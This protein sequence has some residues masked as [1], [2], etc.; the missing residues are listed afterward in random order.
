VGHD[1]AVVGDGPAGSAL[2]RALHVRGVDVILIGDDRPWTATYTTWVDDLD[3]VEWLDDRI[4]LH[5]FGS[6]AVRFERPVHLA[7]SYGVLDN[8]RLR[9]S[10][11]TDV[12]RRTARVTRPDE[13]EARLVIDATGWPPGL[14]TSAADAKDLDP[15]MTWQTAFGV[16]VAHAPDGPL[17]TPTMM[18]FSAP[19]IPGELGVTTFAYSFPVANGWLVEETVLAGGA[20][21][22][23]L[24]APRLASRLELS[25][26][27]LSSRAIRVE[28]V[29][30]PMSI[31]LP[32]RAPTDTVRFGA[33]AAMIHPATGYSVAA[34]VRAADRVAEVVAHRLDRCA[35]AS[36]DVRAVAEAVWPTRLRRARRLHEYGL[37]VLLS[38]D[39][40]EVR[41]FFQTFFEMP[42][43]RWAGYLRIDTPPGALAMTMATMFVRAD[44]RLRR[45]LVSGDP[46]LLV[47]VLRP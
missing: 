19:P 17:G 16:V 10:L 21:D 23:D 7:R 42:E 22:P 12:P 30:I 46:R 14:A 47:R 25:V 45:R 11:R 32:S 3:G 26:D 28:R 40:D 6:V 15:E 39:S 35:D 43:H 1:V 2:A 18:D 13:A 29:R 44:W 38:M 37:D 24:L 34:S 33:A 9:T 4:W 31:D 41:R 8:E 20:I 27:E 5:R 36:G